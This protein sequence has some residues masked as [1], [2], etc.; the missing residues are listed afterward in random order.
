MATARH[1]VGTPGP[2]L[3]KL[4]S[5]SAAQR[6]VKRLQSQSRAT[7]RA[8]AQLRADL[9]ELGIELVIDDTPEGE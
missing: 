5:F 1:I 9:A 3:L 8:F 7:S 2:E 6:E 4:P